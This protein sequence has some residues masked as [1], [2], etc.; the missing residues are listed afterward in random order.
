M[1]VGMAVIKYRGVHI[2]WSYLY[3]IWSVMRLTY[4]FETM[5]GSSNGMR[6][7]F[8]VVNFVGCSCRFGFRQG[9][10][11]CTGLVVGIGGTVPVICF[12]PS[13]VSAGIGAYCYSVHWI[14]G[15]GHCWIC[16]HP[17]RWLLT[18]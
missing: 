15:C 17:L 11:C 18:L 3:Y 1:L 4:A 14:C 16:G 12:G 10:C 8:G 5:L 13:H 9:D 6:V 7:E 2:Y